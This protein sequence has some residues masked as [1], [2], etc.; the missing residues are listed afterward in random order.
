MF[1]GVDIDAA[2]AEVDVLMVA[3]LKDMSRE[4]CEASVRLGLVGHGPH[5]NTPKKPAHHQDMPVVVAM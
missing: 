3:R 2:S 1:I 5:T 4:G